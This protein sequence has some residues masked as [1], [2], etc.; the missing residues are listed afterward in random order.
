VL[1]ASLIRLVVFCPWEMLVL[2]QSLRLFVPLADE[3]LRVAWIGVS[4]HAHCFVM[5]RLSQQLGR[6]SIKPLTSFPCAS[7]I[8]L[9][10]STFV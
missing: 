5:E 1:P 9:S 10:T 6:P 3:L 7:I 2:L 8:F 4:D